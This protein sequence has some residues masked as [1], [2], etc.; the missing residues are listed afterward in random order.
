MTLAEI[1]QELRVIEMAVQAL[2]VKVD[3][4]RAGEQKALEQGRPTKF[5]DLE[6]LWAGV[7]FT[8]EDLEEAEYKVPDDWLEWE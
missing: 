8:E 4:L 2:R 3:Q 1:D 5:T 7:S 6:G